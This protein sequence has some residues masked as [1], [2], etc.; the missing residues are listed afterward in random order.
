MEMKKIAILA[1]ATTLSIGG[2]AAEEKKGVTTQAAAEAK[3]REGKSGTSNKEAAKQ[4]DRLEK[5]DKRDQPKA[6]PSP[7]PSPSPKR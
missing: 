7:S 3:Q 1:V 6:S 5:E 4:L 2:F